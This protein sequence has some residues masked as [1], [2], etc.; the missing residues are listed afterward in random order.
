VADGVLAVT[1]KHRELVDRTQSGGWRVKQ[2]IDEW[3]TSQSPAAAVRFGNT[4]AFALRW[5]A[6][7][8]RPNLLVLYTQTGI[9]PGFLVDQD[10]M[11]VIA[12]ANSNAG[13]AVGLRRLRCYFESTGVDYGLTPRECP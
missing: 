13:M 4:D 9:L 11:A 2:M 3:N 1:I 10:D 8:P 12:P 6:N 5:K 7:D